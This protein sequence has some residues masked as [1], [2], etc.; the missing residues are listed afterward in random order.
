M[1]KRYYGI[2]WKIV[3]KTDSDIQ[4]SFPPQIPDDFFVLSKFPNALTLGHFSGVMIN[5][6][7]LLTEICVHSNNTWGLQVKEKKIDPV[8]LGLRNTFCADT[9]FN[10]VRQLCYCD[11][12]NLVYNDKADYFT[13]HVLD[14]NSE[15]LKY[16]S[17]LCD[18]HGPSF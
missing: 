10:F 7:K 2:K 13:E 17:K 5:K 15:K 3:A 4:S 8:I 16:R 14:G 6:M 11:G 18:M 12:V 9:T 1:T